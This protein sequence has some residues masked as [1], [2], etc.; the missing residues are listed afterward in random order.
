MRQVRRF[1]LRGFLAGTHAVLLSITTAMLLVPCSSFAIA[2]GGKSAMT[3]D[4]ALYDKMEW[5]EIGP[6]R[7]G[8]SIAVAGH[9]DQPST[10]YFGATGGGIWKSTNGGDSWV[11]VSDG[12]LKLGIVGAIEV[13]PSNPNVIYAGTG[14]SCIRGNAMPGEG[15][16]KSYDAGKTWEFTGLGEAQ[17]VSRIQVDPRDENLVYAAVFGHVFGQNPE[18]GIYRSRDGGK[19]WQRILFKDNKTAGV[20]VVIDPNNARIIY[21]ALWEASRSPWDLISGG[22]GSGLWKST[23]AGDTWTDLSANKGMPKGI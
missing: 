9:K 1:R 11:N 23:D 10:Y 15:M 8:R 19:T 21:A 16:Y 4:T 3:V 12:Y 7:G 5:R 13:A 18:R 14:E 20:D 6:F 22:P 2:K 17:T